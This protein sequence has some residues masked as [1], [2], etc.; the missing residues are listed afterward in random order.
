M[1]HICSLFYEIDIEF[2]KFCMCMFRRIWT[3][4]EISRIKNQIFSRKHV[5][6]AFWEQTYEFD[7]NITMI[8]L[9]LPKIA[10]FDQNYR[11][12]LQIFEFKIKF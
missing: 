9:F 12:E 8:E 6:G 5:F 10:I 7:H 11:L 1:I 3:R 2:D 4:I